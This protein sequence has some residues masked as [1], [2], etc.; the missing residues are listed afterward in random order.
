MVQWYLYIQIQGAKGPGP[1]KQK[2]FTSSTSSFK[3]NQKERA[4]DKTKQDEK[5][6]KQ[7]DTINF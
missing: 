2:A 3:N 6:G 4:I 1:K 5:N 7:T